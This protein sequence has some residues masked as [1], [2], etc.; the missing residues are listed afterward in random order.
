MLCERRRHEGKTRQDR[1]CNYG[2]ASS[3]WE[4]AVRG[5]SHQENLSGDHNKDFS[6]VCTGSN[7]NF[8]NRSTGMIAFEKNIQRQHWHEGT[9]GKRHCTAFPGDDFL[10][11][12]DHSH[13]V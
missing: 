7:L 4:S 12:R 3:V 1:M 6:G 13:A 9:A 5:R 11:F 10:K 2:M 8:E